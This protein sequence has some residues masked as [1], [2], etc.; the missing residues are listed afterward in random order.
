MCGI[1]GK[2]SLDGAVISKDSLRDMAEA[3]AHRGPDDVVFYLSQDGRTGLAHRRLAIIDL[4]PLGP[5]PMSYMDR[6]WIVFNGEM[7]NFQEER[8]R[9]E[10]AGYT[11]RSPRA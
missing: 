2:I 7:Y 6:Y 4:S 9:L 11:F 5:Q 10:A 3:I 8:S 1:A